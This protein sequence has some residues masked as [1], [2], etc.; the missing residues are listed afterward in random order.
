MEINL[1]IILILLIFL[2]L[3]I[4]SGR[5]W[6]HLSNFYHK[7]YTFFDFMFL[8]VYFL[9]QFI[10]LLLYNL[11]PQYKELWVSMIVLFA[12]STSGLDK[13]TM[14]ARNRRSSRNLIKSYKENKELW[15]AIEDKDLFIEKLKKDNLELMDFIQ[16]KLKK[17]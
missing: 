15:I 7:N 1:V 10:F 8:G 2:E 17:K 12:I 4:I 14:E 3:V 5:A 13:F 16:T 6:C 9:E 11:V